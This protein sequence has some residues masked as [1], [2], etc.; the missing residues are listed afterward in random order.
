M[1]EYEQVRAAAATLRLRLPSIPSTAIVLG[2]GLASFVRQVESAAEIGYEEIPHWPR[3]STVGHEGRFV[4]GRLRGRT[5][6]I[7]SGRTH[8]Y[9]GNGVGAVTF[10]VRVLG[11]LGVTTL[12]LTSASG[13][14]A[15]G[16]GVG[17]VVVLDDH[18]NLTGVNPLVGSGDPRF[19]GHFLD[20]SE[21]YSPR[22]R[23]IAG[24]AGV[25]AGV[26]V[27]HGVYA[28]LL[29]PSYETPA[30]VRALRSMGADVVGMSTVLEAIAA[31]QMKMEI[32]GLSLV[33]NMAA[34]LSPEPLRHEDVL[35]AGERGA[36]GVATLLGEILG[37]V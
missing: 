28:G 24:A 25:A 37:R 33:T 7:L 6:T 23:A 21:L 10:G 30:E 11:M 26:P 20:M 9:E 18:L 16:L 4:V 15:S 31:R 29:G 36:I 13:G 35:A 19:G 1:T 32:L 12:I 14:I 27:A 2:S 17:S 5:V 8:L 22:L 3:A 34:G